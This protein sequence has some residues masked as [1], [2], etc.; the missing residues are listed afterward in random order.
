MRAHDGIRTILDKFSIRWAASRRAE[1]FT[2]GQ[3]DQNARCGL[4]PHDDCAIKLAQIARDG[5]PSRRP[6]VAY[7]R[8]LWPR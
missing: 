5:Q 4:P 8:A 7:Y 3:C 6:L 1:S 2:C